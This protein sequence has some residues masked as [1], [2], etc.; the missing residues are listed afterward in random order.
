MGLAAADSRHSAD[1]PRDR[2]MA[3]IIKAV[4]SSSL[5]IFVVKFSIAI[6]ALQNRMAQ[7]TRSPAFSKNSNVSQSRER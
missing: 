7:Q 3:V 4:I 5:T 1:G 6:C 2:L